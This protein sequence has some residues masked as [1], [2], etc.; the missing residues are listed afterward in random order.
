MEGCVG[1]KDVRLTFGSE[2][3]LRLE[4]LDGSNLLISCESVARSANIFIDPELG[5]WPSKSTFESILERREGRK[6]GCLRV[7]REETLGVEVLD[8]LNLSTVSFKSWS[9]G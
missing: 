8:G 5:M 9:K 2:E 6:D 7:G 4:V 1:R 3:T